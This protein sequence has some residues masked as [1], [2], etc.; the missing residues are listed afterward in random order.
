M[1]AVTLRLQMM[2]RYSFLYTESREQ[3]VMVSENCDLLGKKAGQCLQA[4][5]DRFQ[6]IGTSCGMCGRT[7][8]ACVTQET[9]E[10][11]ETQCACRRMAW[12]PNNLWC[13]HFSS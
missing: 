10:H 11:A 6:I 13:A 9:R 1:G 5:V 12:R 3:A 2:C 7:R 8:K 4:F